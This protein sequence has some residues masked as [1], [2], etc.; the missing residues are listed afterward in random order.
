M[1]VLL[2]ECLPID[3][4]H[5]LPGHEVH[6]AEWAGYKGLK[7]GE[8]L[9]EADEAGYD[10]LLTIDQGVRHQ[11]NLIGRR[12]AIVVVRART[13]QVEDLLAKVDAILDALAKLRP[14]H[15]SFA[16]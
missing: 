8:L 4:R 11:Q 12:I 16:L 9:Q 7:N 2:D 14:G 5:R 6:T 3:F 15:V 10:A 1:K 13:N